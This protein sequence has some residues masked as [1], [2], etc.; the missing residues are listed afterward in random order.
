MTTSQLPQR[1]P[2]SAVP[3]ER[4]P[5]LIRIE[6][7]IYRLA[8]HPSQPFEKRR[9]RGRVWPGESSAA[10]HGTAL[11]STELAAPHG[12]LLAPFITTDWTDLRCL[13]SGQ[14]AP[15]GEPEG[16]PQHYEQDALTARDKTAEGAGPKDREDDWQVARAQQERGDEPPPAPFLGAHMRLI[17]CG[18]GRCLRRDPDVLGLHRDATFPIASASSS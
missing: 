13:G 1:K 9:G 7:G 11:P 6:Q 14:P 4:S 18:S 10:S 12:A 2:P 16:G 17:G 5:T 15:Q 3:I 8:R